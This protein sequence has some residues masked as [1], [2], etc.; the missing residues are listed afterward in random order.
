M[1]NS[2]GRVD[3]NQI[4]QDLDCQTEKLRTFEGF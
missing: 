1:E 3:K 2:Y 4:L